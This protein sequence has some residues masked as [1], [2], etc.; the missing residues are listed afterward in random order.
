MHRIYPF[1]IIDYAV[2]IFLDSPRNLLK[3]WRFGV[4][5]GGAVFESRSGY[6]LY[7]L[8]YI[9]VFLSSCRQT[10]IVPKSNRRPL[11]CTFLPIQHQ[12]FLFFD[13][14]KSELLDASL[15]IPKTDGYFL[16]LLYDVISN[17]NAVVIHLISMFQ[18]MEV[19]ILRPYQKVKKYSYVLVLSLHEP[20]KWFLRNIV[21]RPLLYRHECRDLSAAK[22]EMVENSISWDTI[23]FS[24][25]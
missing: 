16:V 2:P 10:G 12:F 7:W 14:L 20:L 9:A 18:D 25:T 11:P 3:W 24:W 6:Q 5:F 21:S 23:F 4:L 17:T 19:F 15:N 1:A 13:A 8:S 22:R